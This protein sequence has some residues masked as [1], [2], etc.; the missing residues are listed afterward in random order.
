M[1]AISLSEASLGQ[2]H[3]V[4]M[5]AARLFSYF[6]NKEML[7]K[8]VNDIMPDVYSVNHDNILN[9]FLKNRFKS[10][11]QDDRLLFGKGKNGFIFPMQLQLRK[12]SWNTNDELIFISN[13]SSIKTKH[14]P[15]ICIVDMEGDIKNVSSSF[16]WLF[17]KKFRNINMDKDVQNIQMLIPSFFKVI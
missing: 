15:T 7:K 4:N 3:N 1:V 12:L 11:N 6:S 14:S 8:R 16:A 17:L 9:S 13:V 10:I 5:L 2:I